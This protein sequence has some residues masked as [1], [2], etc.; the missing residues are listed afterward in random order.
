VRGDRPWQIGTAGWAL[1]RA[2]QAAFP[3]EGTHLARY[4]RRLPA[5]EID[6]SFYRPH[7]PDTYARWAGSVPEAF[8]F[9][10]KVPREI[11]HR[12]RLVDT[13]SPLEA[14]LAE[15]AALGERRGPLL[16]QL[17]PSLVFDEPRARRFFEELRARHHGGVALEP[18]HPSWFDDAVD[19]L[20]SELRIARVAADPAC[21]PRA[22]V[23]GGW[24]GLVYFRLHG[25][26]ETYV[27]AY[28]DEF[29]DRMAARIL[30]LEAAAEVWCIFDNTARGEALPD[31]LH[32]WARLRALPGPD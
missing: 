10:V 9:S 18:R 28:S 14:F 4:A 29:L 17:P 22:A 26:P 16:V 3:G 31:A 11:T 25:S 7:R 13:A 8:R 19:G 27:S 32:L 6:S 12:R 24:P 2:R 1:P 5:V 20:L 21:V 23:P 15:S 30:G